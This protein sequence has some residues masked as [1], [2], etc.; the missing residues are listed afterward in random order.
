[1]TTILF[2]N[3]LMLFILFQ[4]SETNFNDLGKLLLGGVAA[5]VVF[6]LVFSFVRLKLQDRNPPKSSFITIGSRDKKES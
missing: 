3:V 5:A 4:D 1:M 2:A 6:A